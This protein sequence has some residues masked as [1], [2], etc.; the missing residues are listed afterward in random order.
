M[1]KYYRCLQWLRPRYILAFNVIGCIILIVYIKYNLHNIVSR[2][3]PFKLGHLHNYAEAL[4]TTSDTYFRR[5]AQFLK[6]NNFSISQYELVVSPNLDQHTATQQNIRELNETYH[7]QLF[8]IKHGKQ[9]RNGCQQSCC[10]SE[11]QIPEFYNGQQNRFPGVFDRLSAIDFKLLADV[12]YG[13]LPVPDEI[14]L[15]KIT[16]DIIP[17]LQNSTVIFVDSI[18]LGHYFEYLHP[19]ISVDYILITGDS[20]ISCPSNVIHTHFHLLDQIFVGTTRIL[21]WFAMNCDVGENENWK[22]SKI[23]TCIPL[24]IN[25]WKDQRLYMQLASGRDDSV[26][27]THLKT[28]AYWILTSFNFGSN[29]IERFFPWYLTCY[30]RLQDISKCFYE[31]N[32]SKQWT[33]YF[34]LAQ[35]R[36]VLSPPGVGSDCYR[37][38]EALYLGSIPIVKTTSINSIFEQLPVLSVNSFGDIT[39]K[40]LQDVYYNMTRRTYDYKRLYKGYWQRQINAFRNPPRNIQIQYTRKSN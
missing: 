1:K 6:Q 22:K 26:R 16:E 25:Q 8:N 34:H 38:W 31:F 14:I 33:Y 36:F 35:S 18:N 29:V 39:L 23:F 13:S 27:N 9:L 3:M 7:Q 4:R 15:P 30:G 20:D 10:W 32:S 24:G 11:I 40:F 37:T 5:I 28:N 19:K 2:Q 21:H 17:C 12:H